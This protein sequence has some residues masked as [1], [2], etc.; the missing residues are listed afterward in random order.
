VAKGRPESRI[1]DDAPAKA[2]AEKLRS[3]RIAIGS[4]S[5]R[6]LGE[7]TFLRHNALSKTASGCYVTW[8]RVERYIAALNLY[9]D[10]AV[11]DEDRAELR[12]LHQLARKNHHATKKDDGE[13]GRQGASRSGNELL[14][15]VQITLDTSAWEAAYTRAP[16]QWH[17]THLAYPRELG[18][19]QCLHELIECMAGIARG[20]GLLS[21]DL[22]GSPRTTVEAPQRESWEPLSAEAYDMLTGKR[23]PDLGVALDFLKRCGGTEGDGLAWT[24]AWKRVEHAIC[25]HRVRVLPDAHTARG[26]ASVPASPPPDWPPAAQRRALPAQRGVWRR[27][28]QVFG[29][30]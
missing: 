12:R 27:L 18:T 8:Q 17:I 21:S 9:R 4:P 28:K 7:L 24:G 16:G 11:T 26:T 23:P 20:A 30:R 3:L 13:T 15:Q 22:A 14:K 1:S 5:Y 2:M 29:G 19:A 6:T 10:G 25:L